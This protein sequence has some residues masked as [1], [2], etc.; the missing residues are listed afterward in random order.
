MEVD[1][2]PNRGGHSVQYTELLALPSPSLF[3]NRSQNLL[4]GQIVKIP[5]KKSKVQSSGR[6][7]SQSNSQMTEIF[8]STGGA[9]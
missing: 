2:R 4:R 8:W 5:V 3:S 9:E 6:S 1:L 7:I